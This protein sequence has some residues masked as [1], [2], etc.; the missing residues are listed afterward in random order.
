MTLSDDPGL[1][2]GQC[3]WLA[4][5]IRRVLAANPSAFTGPGTNSYILGQGRVALVDPGPADA[6]H[7]GALLAALAPGERVEA[8]LVTH[9]HLDHSALAPGL[10]RDLGAPVL[11]FGDAAAGRNP[12]FAA[13]GDLGGGEG[14][15]AGFKPDDTLADGAWLHGP[16][17]SVQALHTPGHFG[18]HL[19]LRWS[20]GGVLTGDHVMGWS[21]SIVSPPDGDMGAYMASLD[22]LAALGPQALFPGHGP[23]VPDGPGR[24]AALIHHRRQREAQIRSALA[25]GPASAAQLTTRVYAD[26]APALHPAAMRNVLA[27]LLDLRARGLARTDGTTGPDAVW[28]AG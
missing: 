9:A 22:R 5:G 21:T 4:P 27:H 26:L 17:W 24:I 12:A 1:V 25:E 8:V 10:A 28:H 13:L 7:R 2:P 15:D 14:V 19:C 20:G 11:A 3:Q 16:D 23:V 18:N 6:A